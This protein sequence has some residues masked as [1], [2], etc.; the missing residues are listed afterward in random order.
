MPDIE[1]RPARAHELGEVA[2]LRWRWVA[3]RDGLPGARRGEFVRAFVAWA[4]ENAVTH[5][6]LVLLLD[7][8]IAGM[9]FLAI[10]ARVPSPHAFGRASG[11]V[12]SVY[13]I[14]GARGGGLGGRLIDAVLDLA[15]E[16]GLE[17]VTV[18]S[19]DRAVSA[20]ERH[21]FAV[22]PRLLVSG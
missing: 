22:S 7:D 3:E 6:C 12:Q 8:R 11:D 2:A 13:V 17:H 14:P 1:I 21:G 10:T 4:E 19:S 15:A 18:R 20:Y 5:R 16:L 9:A